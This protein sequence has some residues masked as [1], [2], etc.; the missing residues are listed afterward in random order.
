MLNPE[1]IKQIGNEVGQVI[2]HNL[3]PTLEEMQREI[4]GIK[5]DMVT[6]W[7]L[8]DK[9]ADLEGSVIIRQRKEDKKVNLLIELLREKSILVDSEVKQLHEFQVFPPPLSLENVGS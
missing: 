8:D 4:A 2:E 3:L 6:K 9:L 5:R 7:Y 1:D